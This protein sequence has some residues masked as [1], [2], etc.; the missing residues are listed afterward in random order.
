MSKLIIVNDDCEV[1]TKSTCSCHFCM[2]MHA[3]VN[4][5]ETFIPTTHLQKEMKKVVSKI[6]NRENE[7]AIRRSPRLAALSL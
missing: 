5:W 4:E 2:S 1:F 7:K 3:S 6:E